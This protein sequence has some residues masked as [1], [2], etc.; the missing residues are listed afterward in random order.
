MKTKHKISIARIVV[1]LLMVALGI[2]FLDLTEGLISGW[3]YAV[4]F[5]LMAITSL[6]NHEDI[7]KFG[8]T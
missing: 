8:T 3:F 2:Y 5:S 4:T 7:V 6:L 1:A